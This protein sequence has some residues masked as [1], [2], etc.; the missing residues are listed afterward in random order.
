MNLTTRPTKTFVATF[1]NW[2]FLDNGRISKRLSWQELPP[3]FSHLVA[4]L[5]LLVGA[6]DY[7]CFDKADPFASMSAAETGGAGPIHR[8]AHQ[9]EG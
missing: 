1:P 5:L 7:L 3:A 8:I 6:S 2:L 4:I 9:E